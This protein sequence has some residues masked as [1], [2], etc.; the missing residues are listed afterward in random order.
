MKREEKY[1]YTQALLNLTLS[2]ARIYSKLF[3][4]DDQKRLKNLECSY[5]D[6]EW[7]SKFMREFMKERKIDGPQNLPPGMAEPYRM[8]QEMIE[9]LPVKLSKLSAKINSKS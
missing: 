7:I 9:L 2:T 8:M 5:R 1:D 4:K 3:E 6:Y